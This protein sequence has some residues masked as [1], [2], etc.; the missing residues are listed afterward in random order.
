[1]YII[2][3]EKEKRKGMP[4]TQ[5]EYNLIKYNILSGGDAFTEPKS[6]EEMADHFWFFEKDKGF[7]LGDMD[8][9]KER[10]IEDD[11]EI[12]VDGGIPGFHPEEKVSALQKSRR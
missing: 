6:A 11:S 2:I 1:M 3:E 4:Y 8:F 5:A 9:F 7:F 12:G 10:G